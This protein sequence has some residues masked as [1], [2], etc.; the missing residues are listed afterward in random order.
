MRPLVPALLLAFA[1]LAAGCV[2]SEPAADDV[3]PSGA[4]MDDGAAP[5][6][7][8]GGVSGA[9]AEDL[10]HQPHLHDYWTGREQ[11]TLFDGELDGSQ[12]AVDSALVAAAFEREARAGGVFFLIPEG[13]IVFEGTGRMVI[14]AT[15]S[16]PLVTSLG[17]SYKHANTPEFSEM[18]PLENGVPLELDIAPEMCDMPHSSTSRWAFFFGPMGNPSASMGAFGLKL[19]IVKMRDIALFPGHPDLFFGETQKAL[20]D[21]HH[22]TEKVSYATRGPY[23]LE[24]GDFGEPEFAPTQVVPMETQMIRIEVTVTGTEA[25]AGEVTEVRFFYRGA[26]SNQLMPGGSGS[27]ADGMTFTW[28][29][30]VTMEMADSP[31]ATTSQ[32]RFMVEPATSMSELDPTCGG[33][34][35]SALEFDAVITAYAVLPED[36]AVEPSGDGDEGSA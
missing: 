35:D 32:W 8:D 17:V 4:T 20:F 29:V 27:L 25:T 24:N 6:P 10:G 16:D 26:D 11:V 30:P 28:D 5:V 9:S 7:A 15:W 33:C 21:G 2:G 36:A 14:T 23:L 22:R 31:Y 19:D 12:S 3:D 34:V 13:N 1:V 18:L